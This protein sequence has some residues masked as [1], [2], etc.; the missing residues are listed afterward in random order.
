[1]R[2]GTT[3][4][5]RSERFTRSVNL[6]QDLT[7]SDALAGYVVT[8]GVRRAALRVTIPSKD[9]SL[10]RAIT[11]TGPY[12]TGKSAFA[13]FCAHLLSP[14][15]WPNQA[16]ARELL[17]VSAPEV[18]KAIFRSTKKEPG[19]LPVVVTGT[20]E[21]FS[22][23]IIRAL[24]RAFETTKERHVTTH[25][26]RLRKLL[27]E[28]TH[29]RDVQSRIIIEALSD[30]I[31][32]ADRGRRSFH[33]LTLVIDELGK[34]LEYAATHPNNSDVYILQ[35]IAEYAVR[36]N[37]PFLLLG[38][39]HQDFS[40]YVERLLLT[41]RVEWEKVRG[42]FEDYAFEEPADEMLRL[43]ALART[44][45]SDLEISAANGRR[46]SAPRNKAS[47]QLL[48]LSRTS[49]KLDLGP[50][51]VSDTELAH[52]LESCRP[53]HPVV[54]IILGPLFR[55]LA[56]NERS[57]FSFLESIEPNGLRDF[58]QQPQSNLELYCTD[59]LYDYLVTSLGPAL[60]LHVHGK[61]WAEIES[62]LSRLPQAT[63]IEVF[64]IKT[65]GLLGAMGQW[66]NL[67]ATRE[68]LHLAG[69]G[70]A[71]TNEIADGLKALEQQSAII[72]RRFNTSYSLWEGSDLDIDELIKATAARSSGNIAIATL[73]EKYLQCRPVVARRHS[74]KTGTLRF[75]SI[76][77]AT[78]ESVRD[79]AQKPLE[80][81]D[82]AIIVVL[83]EHS[84]DVSSALKDAASKSWEDSPQIL[85]S[86]ALDPT[87]LAGSLR[88]YSLLLAVQENTPELAGDPAARKE[89]RARISVARRRVDDA[90]SEILAATRANGENCRW[91][92]CGTNRNIANER[93]LNE[94]LSR[95]SDGLYSKTPP[96]RNEL[97]NRRQL[98]SAAAAA[99]RNLIEAMIG[100]S[101]QPDLGIEGTP[102]EKSIYL[103]LLGV[104]GI[105]RRVG[106]TYVFK[107]PKNSAEPAVKAVWDEIR[108]FFA[109]SEAESKNIA[110]LIE[111][112]SAPP[113]GMK[114]GPIPIVLCAA[115]LSSDSEVALYEDG[116]FVPQL[117]IAVFERLLK[118]PSRFSV[119]RWRVSGIRTTV[120]D[121]L[122]KLL[123]PKSERPSR[124]T[125]QIL[126]VVRP[127]CRFANSL[128]DY[129]RNT[130]SLSP[131]AKNVRDAL[132]RATKP[133]RLLFVE[134]PEACGLPPF[135]ATQRRNSKSVEVFIVAL[136]SA[137]EELRTAY[138]RLL[139]DG[140]AALGQ[141][142]AIPGDATT[143]RESLV[144]RSN[145][146]EKWIA[147]PKLKN[148]VARVLDAN[149]AMDVWTESIAGLLTQRPPNVWRDE[150]KARFEIAATSLARSFRHVEALSFSSDDEFGSNAIRIGIT[151]TALPEIEHIVRIPEQ[152]R[153]KLAAMQRSIFTALGDE[154]R[155]GE[156][157]I[158]LAALIGV[159]QELINGSHG[160]SNGN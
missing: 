159:A 111:L 35:S 18:E 125:K 151:T 150:D 136:K 67:R 108:S 52:L 7:R 128:N 102:P 156:A 38:I 30:S 138:E 13:L 45:G 158:A 132:S 74:F 10:N 117:S 119:Q 54:S 83:P 29:G 110:G 20:R 68:V 133:D 123:L 85:I 127:L 160:A 113:Y 121:R 116:T 106:N 47:D 51:G 131:G 66:R 91:F 77:F 89:L 154:A 61:R 24:L 107:R 70:I 71:T 109:A 153:P 40:A 82:G 55:K 22:V 26:R 100:A 146:V 5:K 115:L 122:A 36:C 120:F 27:R 96:F 73:A 3:K 56:Q 155:N 140:V 64:L 95:I 112:L 79:A 14:P 53:L 57:V 15:W 42:R 87:A 62:V 130:T 98:S 65:I 139:L 44:Q 16:A 129:C 149:L 1:M 126:A 19:F 152:A 28:M 78:A 75:F 81:S 143:V 63:A 31:A 105:H 9:D 8:S 21:S 90:L 49:V 23:A 50:A 32:L 41:E 134:L 148:F 6:E 84:Q 46:K 69:S 103:S 118:A 12:G 43:V 137:L 99:R 33:G 144:A 157:N 147:D 25:L 104:T 39:L 59:R 58:L 86:V 80:A 114:E 11:L 72:Y 145:G 124:A 17:H 101:E 34:L 94:Q 4:S 135:S 92:Y 97:I 76:R 37:K 88:E 141:A 2:G 142:F 60:Y 48:A 93:Q